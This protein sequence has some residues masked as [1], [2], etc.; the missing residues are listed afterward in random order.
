M[1]GWLLIVPALLG[2]WCTVAL[3]RRGNTG[4]IDHEV[5]GV[6]EQAKTMSDAIKYRNS[7]GPGPL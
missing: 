5:G 6:A 1:W 4:T 7:H 3:I 2:I